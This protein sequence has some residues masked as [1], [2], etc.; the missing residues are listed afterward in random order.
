MQN[1]TILASV[2]PEI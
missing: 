2:I 1:Q